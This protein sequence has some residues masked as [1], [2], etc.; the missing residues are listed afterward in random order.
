MLLTVLAW[1][2]LELEELDRAEEAAARGLTIAEERHVR[3]YMPDVLRVQGMILT[4]QERWEEAGNAF[5][6][7]VSLARSMPYPYA[8]A[9][10]L[11]EHGL[12]RSQKGEQQPGRE[13]MEEALAIF[14]RLGARKDVEQ[15]ERALAALARSA[16]PAH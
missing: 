6:E 14:Q 16:D 5:E 1:A 3:L 4:R 9:R 2:Y 7:A 15:A 11:F 13:R 8:E 12:M 10:A